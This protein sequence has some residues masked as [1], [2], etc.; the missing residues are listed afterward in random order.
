MSYSTKELVIQSWVANT[1]TL[2]YTS[3]A[4]NTIIDKLTTTNTTAGA[5]DVSIYLLAPA[6]TATAMT[7]IKT[8]SLSPGECYTW[9]EIVGKTIAVGALL[10]AGTTAATSVNIGMSGR[11]GT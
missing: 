11:V 2:F 10:H 8:R 3:S 4:G 5:L 9:P 1:P 6:G 7:L